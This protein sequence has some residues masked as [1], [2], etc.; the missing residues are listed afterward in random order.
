MEIA[1]P[2]GRRLADRPLVVQAP[3]LGVRC[4]LRDFVP[5]QVEGLDRVVL[6]MEAADSGER[7][8]LAGI[9]PE[10]AAAATFASP[11]PEQQA[12]TDLVLGAAQREFERV[13]SH[14]QQL[15]GAPAEVQVL[16]L[17]G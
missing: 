15:A 9:A 1:R 13:L 16:D 8:R 5:V 7:P 17:E 4:G 12:A 2:E 11:I 10:A 3:D 6:V 14:G